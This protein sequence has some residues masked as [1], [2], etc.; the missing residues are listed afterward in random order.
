[1][2]QLLGAGDHDGVVGRLRLSRTAQIVG[3][4]VHGE[5]Q[6]HHNGNSHRHESDKPT[7]RVFH[8]SQAC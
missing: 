6:Q 8:R 5:R 2:I 3:S 4:V 7:G 1:M